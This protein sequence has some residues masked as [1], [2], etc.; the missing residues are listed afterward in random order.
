MGWQSDEAM[1]RIVGNVRRLN[2]ERVICITL[3]RAH[4]AGANLAEAILVEAT[5]GSANL[6]GANLDGANLYAES[7]RI[8]N[9]GAEVD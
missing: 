9:D 5:L 7:A 4:L 3:A 6:Q 8:A 1:Y 2:R